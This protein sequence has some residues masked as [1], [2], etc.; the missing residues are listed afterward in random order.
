VLRGRLPARLIALF[1]I[2]L[3][4]MQQDTIYSLAGVPF[5][6]LVDSGCPSDVQGL[7]T[8]QVRDIPRELTIVDIWTILGLASLI[9][10]T[11]RR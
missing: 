11:D 6:S 5:M 8:I 3:G 9:P 7:V 4:Y 1:K 2:L 10:E